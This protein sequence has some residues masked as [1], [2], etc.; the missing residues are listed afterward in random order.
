[1]FLVFAGSNRVEDEGARTHR[2]IYDASLEDGGHE[3]GWYPLR[4]WEE[5]MRYDGAS[6]RCGW[7]DDG[8]EQ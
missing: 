2:S 7:Y 4:L 5:L 1:M 3:E 8:S 6:L